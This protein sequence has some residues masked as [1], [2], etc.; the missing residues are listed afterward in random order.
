MYL[1]RASSNEFPALLILIIINLV[2]H[3]FISQSP[4]P[5]LL[6][7]QFGW[8]HFSFI[9]SYLAGPHLHRYCHT[10]GRRLNAY[11]NSYAHGHT[12]AHCH[13]PQAKPQ[14][15][16]WFR[17]YKHF[18]ACL[19]PAA[20]LRVVFAPGPLLMQFMGSVCPGFGCHWPQSD[21]LWYGEWMWM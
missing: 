3:T 16:F 8:P 11:A 18:A 17:A 7:P 19:C 6:H 5:F 15:Q 2:D 14:I 12:H 9:Y 21:L 20:L 13:A 4:W 10:T 1:S